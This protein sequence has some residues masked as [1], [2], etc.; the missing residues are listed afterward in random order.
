[1]R[2]I[3]RKEVRL[4]T[5]T[6]VYF[7]VLFGFMFLLPGYPVLCG[8]FFLTLGLYQNF[9]Y[10]RE[11]NDLVF[12]VLLPIA[13]Q[14]VVK[15]KFAFSCMIEMCCFALMFVSVLVR[16]TVFS[17]SPVYRGNALM[18]ANLFALGMALV[19][20]GVFNL[21]FIGSFFR[22]GYKT[23][24]PFITYIVICFIMIGVSESLHHF[25]GMES[26]N[27]F[28]FDHISL[29]ITTLIVG[30]ICY[31]GLTILSYRESCSKFEKLDL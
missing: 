18:N 20:F 30:A 27:S 9:R 31:M 22:T 24:R 8:A 7:F 2:N 1:M 5:L 6:I 15:G 12:S 13:K 10:A 4:G 21:V 17:D 28:G 25:P 11:C 26:L 16:M 19:L 14:D 29:Q 3:L 23:G